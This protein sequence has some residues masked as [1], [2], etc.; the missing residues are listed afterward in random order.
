MKSLKK[1]IAFVTRKA[2]QGFTLIELAI[3][4]IFLG[5]LAVFAIS[6]FANSAT[7]TTK[8]KSLYEAATKLADN[9]GILAQ[10]C[11]QPN[12]IGTTL[13]SN[14]SDTG[15]TTTALKNL[16]MLLGSTSASPVAATAYQACYTNSGIR[17]LNGVSTGSPGSETVQTYAIS[18]ANKVVNGRNAVAVSYAGVPD[19]VVL[20][21]YNS[22]S[23]ASGAPAATTLPASDATD[24]QLQFGTATSGKRS[25]TVI[26]TL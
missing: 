26:R 24:N 8:S 14:A 21:M 16:A 25:V 17:P 10:T 20:A 2:Q 22:Y 11:G 15:A 12:D 3:V 1:T 9:W 23:S 18:V 13:I 7:D 4:G 6:M 19:N 5:L